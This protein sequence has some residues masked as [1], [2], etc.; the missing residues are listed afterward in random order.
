MKIRFITLLSVAML[1]TLSARMYAQTI[2]KLQLKLNT[3]KTFSFEEDPSTDLVWSFGTEAL[4]EGGN[5][6]IDLVNQNYRPGQGETNRFHLF[7]IKAVREG[8]QKIN[9][10][11]FGIGNT[12][13]ARVPTGKEEEYEIEVIK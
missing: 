7:T 3:E 10:K 11:Q 8:K 12:A 2:Q 9:F 4:K 1:V 6:I 13:G 5:N